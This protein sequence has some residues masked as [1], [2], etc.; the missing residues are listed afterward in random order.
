VTIEITPAAAEVLRRSLELVGAGGSSLG[1]RL[2][3]AGGEVRP[4]F[5][6]E[7]SPG[8]ETLEL[9][10]LRVFVDRRILE[11]HGDVVI[12]VTAE[13]ETIVVRPAQPGG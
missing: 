13:H 1:V 6:P 9:E 3:Q 7:P 8:D 10:D 4:R 11:E 12:D 2:R 5:A